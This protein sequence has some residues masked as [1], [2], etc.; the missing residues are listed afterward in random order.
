MGR[1]QI[2][3]KLTRVIGAVLLF[4]ISYVV[5]AVMNAATISQPA[6][7]APKSNTVVVVVAPP[8]GPKAVPAEDR[9][10]ATPVMVPRYE[11]IR[12]EP[13]PVALMAPS[14]LPL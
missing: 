9:T 13:A 4:G 7:V 10:P 12:H 6:L 2:S 8:A 14:A 5:S 3:R 1:L 11:D